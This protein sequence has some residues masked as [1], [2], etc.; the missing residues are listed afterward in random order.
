MDKI[1]TSGIGGTYIAPTC[2]IIRMDSEDIVTAS[3]KT[4]AFWGEEHE[5]GGGYSRYE[6]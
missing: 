1:T 6:W 4:N 5:F 3:D 2:E